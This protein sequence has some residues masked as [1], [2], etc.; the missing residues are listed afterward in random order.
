[1]LTSLLTPRQAA[2]MLGVSES[3]ARRWCD[4]GLIPTT[5]TIGKHRRIS[6][7]ELV[8][9]ARRQG[10]AIASPAAALAGAGGRVAS[11]SLLAER[12]HQLLLSAGSLAVRD[13]II[14]LVTNAFGPPIVCDEILAP[15]MHRIGDEWALGRVGIYQEHAATSALSDALAAARG[16]LPVPNLSAPLAI[17]ASLSNDPYSLGPAMSALVL[18]NVGYRSLL[19]GTDMPAPALERAIRA[20]R[21]A[22]VAASRS[23]RSPT[24]DACST[25]WNRSQPWHEPRACAWWSGA[26]GS[27]AS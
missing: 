4:R 7:E 8:A 26:A 24:P 11:P 21:A 12:L 27:T 14:D 20:T 13:F 18:Q 6:R 9:F 15:A 2:E 25:A 1:M 16:A 22:I 10:I 19:L 23:A 5:R 3:T 17:C